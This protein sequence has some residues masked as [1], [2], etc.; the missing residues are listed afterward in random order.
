MMT[1]ARRGE[2]CALRWPHVRLEEQRLL[3]TRNF[4][5]VGKERE[6]KDTKPTK[7]ASSPSTS[8]MAASP[9]TR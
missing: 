3:I 7:V 2:L 5:H 8:K 9:R 1:G 6:E 4:V